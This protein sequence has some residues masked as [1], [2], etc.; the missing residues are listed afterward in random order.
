MNPAPQGT[1]QVDEGIALFVTFGI[2]GLLA[3]QQATAKF[4]LW[5]GIAL[6]ALVW[7][8][9]IRSGRAKTFISLL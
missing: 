6:T 8:N 9:A 3:T 5:V 1:P 2:L 4:A 7:N